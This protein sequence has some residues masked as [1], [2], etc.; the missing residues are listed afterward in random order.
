MNNS[1]SL[2]CKLIQEI[3]IDKGLYFYISNQIGGPVDASDLL[4]WQWVQSV[5]ALDKLIHDLVRIGMVQEYQGI[6]PATSAFNTFPLNMQTELIFESNPMF[7][8]LEFESVVR[9]KFGTMSFQ[10][11]LKI[12]DAL[13]Y[14][15]IENHK[16][17]EIATQLGMPEN[18][19]KEKQKNIV[20]RRNQIVHEADYQDILGVRQSLTQTDVNDVVDFEYKLGT[21]IFQL[22]H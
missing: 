12:A 22:V 6:R 5:S 7:A 16:W 2:F 9:K 20:I 1:Y 19:C 10:D 17:K 8:P 21:A 11:P 13:A 3:N 15:W 4:R 14:I 18:A